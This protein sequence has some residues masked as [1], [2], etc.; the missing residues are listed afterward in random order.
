MRGDAIRNLDAVLETGA[1]LL[2]ED[3]STSIATIAAEAGVDRRTVYR[4]FATRE[5][6]LAA[7]LHKKLDAVDEA[8]A[9]ARLE[10]APPAVALHRWVEGIIPVIRRYP[11]DIPRM[12][13]ENDEDT[14]VYDRMQGQ[15]DQFQ[16]F[17]HRAIDQGVLRSGLPDGLPSALLHQMVGLMARQFPDIE[18][19]P[20]AD[21]VVDAMLGG[22][23]QP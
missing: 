4:R 15:R 21:I 20:A 22:I 2:A 13:C 6:L 18:P 7:V 12:C 10:S 23:G 16:A 9:D 3:P 11:I 1:R 17:V 19:A 8:L 14:S 5:A